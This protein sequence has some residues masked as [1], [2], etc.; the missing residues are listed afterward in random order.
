MRNVSLAVLLVAGIA[1]GMMTGVAVAQTS[2][3]TLTTLVNFGNSNGMNP[4]GGLAQ[5][6]DGDFYGMIY[7]PGRIL[8]NNLAYKITTAGVF[9][10][11]TY[12]CTGCYG[13]KPGDALVLAADGYLYGTT[14]AGGTNG[15]GTI[16]QASGI[17]LNTIYSFCSLP[18]CAD[19][20]APYAPLT[21]GNDGNLY[22]TTLSGGANGT[23]TVFVV[24]TQGVETVLHS[25]NSTNDGGP[26]GL[27]LATDG[28]FYGTTSQGGTGTACS[29]GTVGCGT[30][31]RIT[32]QGTLT[33]LYS[34]CQLT[35][36]PDGYYPSG[37]IQAADGDL[38]GTTYR[39]GNGLIS[40]GTSGTVFK[41]TTQSTFTTLYKFCSLANCADGYSPSGVTQGTDGNLYGGAYGGPGPT[42]K[43]AYYGCGILYQMTTTGTPTTLYSFCPLGSCANSSA[44]APLTQGTD[45]N[46]YGVT[47]YGGNKASGTAFKLNVGLGPFVRTVMSSGTVGSSVIILGTSLTGASKVTFNGVSAA[48]TVVSSSEITATVPAG[49]TTG[50]VVVTTR[51]ASLKSNRNYQVTN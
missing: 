15:D 21:L 46:F 40:S 47:Y 19:G 2:A 30:V 38:Y 4:V 12:K 5:G 45:G 37:L 24:T 14:S 43:N 8:K 3:A 6:L 9:T 41:I 50:A 25:F 26:S 48:F 31:F 33:T 34:F 35:N 11:L 36:C 39:G 23:G 20:S 10:S 51:S 7:V 16:V 28:N 22:G 27:V 44:P 1:L 49:A 32:P 42:C 29:G 18:A 17:G 13:A